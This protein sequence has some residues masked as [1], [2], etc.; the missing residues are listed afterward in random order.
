MPLR[1]ILDDHGDDIHVYLVLV[2]R[3]LAVADRLGLPPAMLMNLI[4]LAAL[5]DIEGTH[6]RCVVCDKAAVST[7]GDVCITCEITIAEL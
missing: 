5:D 1:A 6:P 7:A 3:L 4:L 2:K